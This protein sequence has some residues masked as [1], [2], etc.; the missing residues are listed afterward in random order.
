[1]AHRFG[2]I[3]VDHTAAGVDQRPLGLS[4][5]PEEALACVITQS[6]LQYGLQT[7]TI[8]R[9][10][11]RPT[12]REFAFPVLHILRYVDDDRAGPACTRKLERG[13]DC[14]FQSLRLRDEKNVFGD[15]A[16]DRCDWRFLKGVCTNCS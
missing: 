16:H 13:P 3:A 9:Q 11:Q 6:V 5:H 7:V 1:M 15:R 4:Q 12:A 10:W 14:C 8:S 2:R